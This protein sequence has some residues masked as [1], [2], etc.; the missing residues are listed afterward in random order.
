MRSPNRRLAAKT[1]ATLVLDYLTNY[2]SE[3][4]IV[5]GIVLSLSLSLSLYIYVC[6]YVCMYAAESQVRIPAEPKIWPL[7]ISDK[8]TIFPVPVQSES[9]RGDTN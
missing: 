3:W 5:E 2:Y 8:W 4:N 9:I 6:M 1:D 7:V